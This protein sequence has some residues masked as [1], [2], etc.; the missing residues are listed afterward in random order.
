MCHLP[1]RGPCVTETAWVGRDSL[2]LV[3]LAQQ[4]EE[5][6]RH[7]FLFSFLYTYFYNIS[8]CNVEGNNFCWFW[9]LLKYFKIDLGPVQKFK[10]GTRNFSLLSL[11]TVFA[12]QAS[13]PGQLVFSFIGSFC[14]SCISVNSRSPVLLGPYTHCRNGIC[15]KLRRK[16]SAGTRSWPYLLVPSKKS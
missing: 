3:G 9:G 14:Y 15:H 8:L 11:W 7:D 12:R 13:I 10:T 6:T 16:P 2:S 5:K 1:K 4:A